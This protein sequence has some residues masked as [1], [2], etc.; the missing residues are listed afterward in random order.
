TAELLRGILTEA[1]R[2]PLERLRALV[3][4]FLRSECEEA[5]IRVALADAAPL[6]RDAPEA[7]EA[8]ASGRRT[9]EAFM[10][11][12]LPSGSDA[13]RAVAGELVMTTLSAVGKHFSGRSRTPAEIAAYADALADMLCAYLKDAGRP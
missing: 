4:A 13:T 9:I 8:R 2:P 1:R 11:E 12:A 7:Q 6:Y 10:R 3:H 5:A